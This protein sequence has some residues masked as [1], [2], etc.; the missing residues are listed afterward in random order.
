MQNQLDDIID[1]RQFFFKVIRSWFLFFISLLVTFIIA[2]A[3]NRYTHELFH[4]ETSILIKE[5]NNISS[6]SE[7]LY[8]NVETNKRS[9]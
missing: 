2:F 8:D 4:V 3:Y 9:L 6:A 1:F 5:H 7:L